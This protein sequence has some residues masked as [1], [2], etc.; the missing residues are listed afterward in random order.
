MTLERGNTTRLR[1]GASITAKNIDVEA[2]KR[3]IENRLFLAFW[4]VGFET[5]YEY[6]DRMIDVHGTPLHKVV[7][8]QCIVEEMAFVL[9][10][11]IAT[12]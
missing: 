12:K 11:L 6:L 3:G 5:A 2:G 10:R 1:C 7:Y 9:A 8:V 4:R